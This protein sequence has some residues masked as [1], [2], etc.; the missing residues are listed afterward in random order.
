ASSS[1]RISAPNRQAQ[2]CLNAN[3]PNSN[4]QPGHPG[5]GVNASS[6]SRIAPK[7]VRPDTFED[8]ATM[9]AR[10]SSAGALRANESKRSRLRGGG[11]SDLPQQRTPGPEQLVRLR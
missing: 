2:P 1:A 7:R 9:L 3:S 5:D 4:A 11:A 10:S 6:R 8:R